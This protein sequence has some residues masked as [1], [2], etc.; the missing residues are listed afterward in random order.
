[1]SVLPGQLALGRMAMA[2]FLSILVGREL[3]NVL[4]G[5]VQGTGALVLVVALVVMSIAWLY[6][7]FLMAGGSD[8][9]ANVVPFAM[10]VGSSMA[11]LV[12][13][14]R[15]GIY[16]VYYSAIVAGAVYRWRIGLV[17]V[18]V[19]SVV[20]LIVWASVGGVISPQVPLI[21][22]LLGGSSVIVRVYVA[23]YLQLQ[24]AR[25]ELN[26]LAGA[27]ARAGLARNLHDRVGQQLSAVILQ[28]E[29]LRMDLADSADEAS[30]N[31]ASKVVKT[32]RDALE[33][34]RDVVAGETQPRLMAESEVAKQLLEASGIRCSVAMEAGEVPPATDGV[35]AWVVREGTS[36]V[37]R[38][39]G[40]R[41]C[42]I[43]VRREGPEVVVDVSDDGCGANGETRG[44]GLRGLEERL[45]AA[46]GRLAVTARQPHG[47]RMRA[48]MPADVAP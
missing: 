1:M 47:L 28:G 32:A 14:P 10:I 35:L 16:P 8:R 3:R 36:N 4:G 7:W 22:A 41:S 19:V 18:A 23:A 12:I 31:R 43:V 40:A 27:E 13:N 9:L 45:R 37:M 39:S 30:R 15:S 25:D 5:D 11:L 34:M 26:R 20:G 29:L 48:T 2:A 33:G 42:T 44:N 17:L 21:V 38:H 46:G 6:F 24:A